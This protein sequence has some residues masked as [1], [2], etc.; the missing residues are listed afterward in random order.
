MRFRFDQRY[1]MLL[2]HYQT[3]EIMKVIKAIPAFRSASA[4]QLFEFK[5]GVIYILDR[6][7]ETRL[8]HCSALIDCIQFKLTDAL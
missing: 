6:I 7:F 5:H 2:V 3:A 1:D 4:V 8:S